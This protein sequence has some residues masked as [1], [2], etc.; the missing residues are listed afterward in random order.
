MFLR[1]TGR[2]IGNI[3][4]GPIHPHHQLA[5]VSLLIGAQDCWGHGFATEAIRGTSVYAFEQLGVLKLSASMYAPNEGSMHAFVKAG[6]QEEGRRRRHY[7]LN[8]ERC[9]LIELGLIP[10]DLAA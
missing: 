10:A 2:H 1:N 8:G 7:D 3:K 9:D 6:Y 4:V 5:D